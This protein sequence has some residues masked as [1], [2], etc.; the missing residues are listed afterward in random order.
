[1]DA[2][3]CVLRKPFHPFLIFLVAE[4]LGGL[5]REAVEVGTFKGFFVRDSRLV[6]SHL[7][8]ANDT[9]LIGEPRWRTRGL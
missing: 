5:T 8:Y 3:M 1:M 9:L 4:G 6:I 2:G 7:Q